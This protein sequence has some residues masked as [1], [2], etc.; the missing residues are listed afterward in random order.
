MDNEAT[1][2]ARCWWAV[3][4]GLAAFWVSVFGGLHALAV[5]DAGVWAKFC[6]VWNAN[7]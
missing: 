2:R 4:I 3:L 5:Q 1:F 7:R 6:P